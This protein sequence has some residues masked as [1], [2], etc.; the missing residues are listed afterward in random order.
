VHTQTKIRQSRCAARRQS[1]FQSDFELSVN[2]TRISQPL[3][4]WEK[5]RIPHA[6]PRL[7]GHFVATPNTRVQA[8]QPGKAAG[9][10]VH[11]QVTIRKFFEK[12]THGPLHRSALPGLNQA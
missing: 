1:C 2:A 7:K 8:L 9:R 3:K 10:G 11:H 4:R 6:E 12:R 5:R